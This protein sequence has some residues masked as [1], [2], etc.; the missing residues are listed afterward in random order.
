[1]ISREMTTAAGQIPSSLPAPRLPLSQTTARWRSLTSPTAI[2]SAALVLASAGLIGRLMAFP[3]RRDEQFYLTM[4]VLLPSGDLYR[5]LGFNH[6]P[7]LPLMLQALLGIF[8]PERLLLF[9]RF[10]MVG[11]WAVALLSLWLLVVRLGGSRIGATVSSVVLA[12]QPLLLGQAGM[13]VTNNFVP[14]AMALAAAYLF[15]SA[16]DGGPDAGGARLPRLFASGALIG[17]AICTKLNFV[18]LLPP[19]FAVLGLLWLRGSVA[20]PPVST[21]VAFCGGLLLGGAPALWYFLNDMN[22]FLVHVLGYHR[23]PHIAYWTSPLTANEPKVM[24]LGGKLALAQEIWLSSSLIPVIVGALWCAMLARGTQ[25]GHGILRDWRVLLLG[26]LIVTAVLVSFIPAP[27]FPQYY[28]LPIAFSIAL[29]AA[30][31]GRL[32]SGQQALARPVIAI[33]AAIVLVV[34]APRLLAGLPQLARPGTWTGISTHEAGRQIAGALDAHGLRGKVATLSPLYALEGDLPIFM[35]LA[36]GQFMYR[37]ADMMPAS[38]RPHYRI[39]SPTT[40]E[41]EL[42]ARPPA[43]VLVGYDGVLDAP[44]RR[45]AEHAGYTRLVLPNMRTRYGQGVLYVRPF[46]SEA[47]LR[48]TTSAAG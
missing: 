24:G 34:G 1:M 39:F 25:G 22:G 38:H 8:E 7:G 19:T 21:L 30:L 23:G 42:A 33:C 12:A 10:V 45:F 13:S 2:W 40:I 46:R 31:Y 48:H 41:A 5:D 36:G 47:G 37:V 6:P 20:A 28:M 15:V 44:L 18:F 16:L 17:F 29:V 14:L 9:G 4:G 27:A 43:A 26:G 32:P 3:I 35:E 11:A